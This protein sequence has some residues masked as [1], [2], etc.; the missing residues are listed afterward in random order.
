MST[1]YLSLNQGVFYVDQEY[2]GKTAARELRRRARL[3]RDRIADLA[4]DFSDEPI[5][6]RSE[7]DSAIKYAAGHALG[8]AYEFKLSSL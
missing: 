2:K 6:L 4:G 1:L 3:M 8:K 7:V 5:D